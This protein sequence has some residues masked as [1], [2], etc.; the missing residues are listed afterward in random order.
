MHQTYKKNKLDT[1]MQQ[2][3]HK[4]VETYLTNS[5]KQGTCEALDYLS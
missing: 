1:I 3:Q 5:K 4:H 2:M